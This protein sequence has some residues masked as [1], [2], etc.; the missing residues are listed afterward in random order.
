MALVPSCFVLQGGSV[1][2][3]QKTVEGAMLGWAGVKAVDLLGSDE[4]VCV[5]PVRF[6]VLGLE[7]GG[8]GHPGS[9]SHVCMSRHQQLQRGQS[10]IAA[11]TGGGSLLLCLVRAS[12]S[13][14][15]VKKRGSTK[16]IARHM[17]QSERPGDGWEPE[18]RTGEK[19]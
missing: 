3:H 9:I 18:K 14:A 8:G 15:G 19:F 12:A 17:A 2:E 4:C 11:S 5:L 7:W 6:D 10:Q 1:G 16:C 13:A